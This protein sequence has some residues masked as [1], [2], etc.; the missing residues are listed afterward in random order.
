MSSLSL[1]LEQAQLIVPG[2]E[3]YTITDLKLAFSQFLKDPP[4]FQ[5]N[6][7][8]LVY[9]EDFTPEE[10]CVLLL[11]IRSKGKINLIDFISEYGQSIKPY[12]SLT[13]IDKRIS[14]LKKMSR[15]QINSIIDTFAE[16]ILQE[17]SFF[18]STEES[19]EMREAGLNPVHFYQVR[20]NYMPEPNRKPSCVILNA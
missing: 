6:Q 7:N 12:R 18:M 14:Q 5:I 17:E 20:C 13:Q 1:P 3:K 2:L 4:Q 16:S 8:D 15:T 19:D 9:T 11:Y 10:D